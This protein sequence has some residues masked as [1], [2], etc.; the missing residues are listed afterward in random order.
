MTTKIFFTLESMGIINYLYQYSL[1]HFM[2]VVFNVLKLNEE[3]KAIPKSDP[4]RRLSMIVKQLFLKI[5]TEIGH[6]LLDEHTILFTLAL[7]QIRLVEDSACEPLF[8]IFLSSPTQL[9]PNRIS[10]GLLKG[11][12]T[13]SQLAQLEDISLGPH[14]QGL[15]ASM[16]SEE[17]RWIQVLDSASPEQLVPEPW[18][19]G[20]DSST[21]NETARLLKKLIIIKIIRPD[22]LQIAVE[23]FAVKALGNEIQDQ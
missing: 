11:K 22:R 5:N 20:N 1:Q 18:M 13:K 12:L 3:V 16:E 9:E 23:K 15:I 7:A 19:T 10:T 14:L 4:Q 8:T 21:S 2:D 6:G 17:D